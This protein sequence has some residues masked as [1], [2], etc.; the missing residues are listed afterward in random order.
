MHADLERQPHRQRR[1]QMNTD[2]HRNPTCERQQRPRMHADERGFCKGN[3]NGGRGKSRNR[4]GCFLRRVRMGA[5]ADLFPVSRIHFCCVA[6]PVTLVPMIGS[7]RHRGLA[8]MFLDD[9]PRGIRPDL[10]RRCQVRLSVLHSATKIDDLRLPGFHLH[11]LHGIPVRYALSVNGPW[12]ITFEWIEDTAW[13]MNPSP[14]P[15]PAPQRGET[16]RQ[17]P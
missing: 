7:F 6:H 2:L 9:D 14:Y 12:R 10:V 17:I 3:R 4:R 11:R 8:R 16:E 13:R 5:T 1:P 15:L